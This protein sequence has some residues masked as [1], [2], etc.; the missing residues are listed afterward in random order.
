[1]QDTNLWHKRLG[2]PS[3]QTLKSVD[4]LQYNKDMDAINT[5][6]VC[7]LAKQ[8]RLSFPVS[9]TRATKC[10]DLVHLDLWGP[11]K[12]PTFDKEHYFLTIVDDCSRYTW[13]HLL[14]LKSET[15]V[16]LNFF[17]Q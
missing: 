5:C 2:H 13:I 17:L 7:P 10:F 16:A 6:H 11:Y 3:I 15:I 9:E 8:T 14:Q 1:M 12:I 4:F